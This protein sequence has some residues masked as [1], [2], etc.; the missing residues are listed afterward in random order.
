M[1]KLTTG[2]LLAVAMLMARPVA[3]QEL[4]GSIEGTVKDASG[5][6]LPG[7]TVEARNTATNTPQVGV[8]DENGVFRFPSLVP[9]KYTITATLS[10]FE[11]TKV[12]DIELGLGRFRRVDIVLAVAGLSESVQVRAATPIVDVKQN[13]V[14]ATIN[15]DIIALLPTGR[16][17]LDAIIGVAGTGLEGRGGGLMIDGAGA[18]ENRYL[19]DGLDTTNLRTGVAAVGVVVDFVEQIQVKQSGY[20]AEFRAS[21]GGVVSAITKSGTNAFHGGVGGYL[22]GR[23]LR[24][25]A[26]D[27]RPTLRLVPS[28]NTK[29]E[30]FTPPR[31]NETERIEQVYDIGGPI[32]KNHTWFWFGYN[33]VVS[34]T[35][36]TVTWTNN[37]GFPPTQSFNAR[38]TS[39]TYQYNVTQQLTDSMRIRVTGANTP[40]TGGLTLPAIDATNGTSSS[41]A[42]S[43]N[44]RPTVYTGSFNNSYT[45]SFDWVA[46]NRLYANITGGYLAYGSGSKGGT[47][48][49]GTVRSFGTTNVNYLDVPASL[50]QLSGFVD[51]NSNSFTRFDNYKRMSLNSDVTMFR[52]W[53]GD[54]AFKLGVQV[55]RIA[56]EVSSGSQAPNISFSWN[57]SRATLSNT[58]VRGKYGYYTVQR[59]YTE[60]DIKSNNLGLFLQDQWTIN[61]KLTINYGVRAEHTEIPSY[62]PQNPGI[63]FGWGDK[64]APRLGFAYDV[65]GDGKWKAYGSWGTFYDIEKLDMPRGAWGADRWIAYYWT[66][67]DYNWNTIDCTGQPGSGCRG[68]FIEQVDFRH[69]SNDPNDNLVDPNLKPVKTQELTLGIDHELTQLMSIGVRYAH[70]WLNETIEDVGVQ[71]PGVGEVYYIANPGKGFGEYPLGRAF[72]ATPKPVRKYDG[73]DFTF[74]RRLANNWFV[75]ANV[76]VSRTWGNYAGLTNSDENGR[77]SPNVNRSF[78]GLYMA[79]G[80]DGKPLYGRLQSDRP[81][82]FKLQGAYVMPWGT[83]V[84]VNFVAFSGLP[85]T[86]SV[87]YKGVP[88][89]VY[90]RNDIGRAPMYNQ[91][92]LN[93]TQSFSLPRNMRLNAQFNIDNLFDQMTVTG[94]SAAAYRDAMVLTSDTQFF[95]GFSTPAVVAAM[96]TPARPDPR[97]KLASSWQGARAARLSLKFTF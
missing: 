91:T 39:K 66:L 46:N 40:S 97:Y 79:F 87:T 56:N 70:K 16:N 44:P 90:G 20:N 26:G 12:E 41:N 22:T 68:T 95:A 72:P 77:N 36:R 29:A 4:R 17:F 81:V 19:V 27:P 93:F 5:G 62:Q 34:D 94:Y 51:N 28:D 80:Q 84:G 88:V 2:L 96:S 65:K 23:R 42:T 85:N 69:V 15:K 74:K 76:L 54:H 32:F 71:V 35:D 9:G 75:N 83:Q 64:I 43:F 11:T 50:Q 45:A 33:D 60:G 48:Y 25:L 67:D 58:L 59:I 92:D 38:T 78:D 49:P 63:T 6:V 86:T 1:R 55:E 61:P 73:V 10:G 3:A 52:D 7:V 89:F 31:L 37:R 18:S 53:H 14:T 47:Y 8:T 57:S 82:Q 30:F 13:S 21:T 24:R